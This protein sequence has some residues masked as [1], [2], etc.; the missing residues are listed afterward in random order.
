M[1][2]QAYKKLGYSVDD[3]LLLNEIITS[4]D[5][6]PTRATAEDPAVMWAHDRKLRLHFLPALLFANGGCRVCKHNGVAL[7]SAPSCLYHSRHVP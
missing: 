3:Q 1:H 5:Y 7:H 4:G 2:D 6:W